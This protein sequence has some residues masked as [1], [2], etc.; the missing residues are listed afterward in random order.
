[1]AR[2]TPAGAGGGRAAAAPHFRSF[3]RSAFQPGDDG[4]AARKALWRSMYSRKVV[5]VRYAS[6]RAALP[7]VFAYAGSKRRGHGGAK[8]SEY[9]AAMRWTRIATSAFETGRRAPVAHG[10]AHGAAATTAGAA[11]GAGGGAVAG[12]AAG[13]AGGAATSG[14]N[15][16][17]GRPIWR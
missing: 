10:G 4:L 17:L 11:A 14:R 12:P 15:V 1:M 2:A 3:V 9:A 8:G 6:H 5:A 7:C 16:N 13:A